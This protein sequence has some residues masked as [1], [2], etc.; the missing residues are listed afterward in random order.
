M[1]NGNWQGTCVAPSRPE[2][3]GKLPSERSHAME[4]KHKDKQR[5][6]AKHTGYRDQA[7]HRGYRDVPRQ[8]EACFL[9]TFPPEAEEEAERRHSEHADAVVVRVSHVEPI[10]LRT[11]RAYRGGGGGEG[12]NT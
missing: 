5:R 2:E 11:P 1:E 6:Q 9:L 3:K 4:R 8:H 10:A 12:I 7:K